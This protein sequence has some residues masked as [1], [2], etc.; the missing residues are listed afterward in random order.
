M[1]DGI[2]D[3]SNKAGNE[4]DVIK[5]A[6]LLDIVDR[7]LAERKDSSGRFWYVDTHTARPYH[8]LSSSGRWAYG[9]GRMRKRADLPP[10]F[11]NYLASSF[12]EDD[13]I[14]KKKTAFAHLGTRLYLGSSAIVYQRI[15]DKMPKLP[16]AMTLFDIDKNVALAL[17]DYYGQQQAEPVMTFLDKNQLSE[18]GKA[19]L[20][21]LWN[22][23]GQSRCL[24]IKGSSYDYLSGI[25]P[26]S[27]EQHPDLVFVD[28]HKFGDQREG[29][30][31][32]LAHCQESK[33]HFLCWTPL[34]AVP[35]ETFSPDDWSFTFHDDEKA[36]VETCQRQ[37]YRMAWFAWGSVKGAKQ[38]CYGCQ[39]TFDTSCDVSRL[40]EVVEEVR[41]SCQEIGIR[42][43]QGHFRV[44]CWPE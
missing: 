22:T 16:L 29:I 12:Y 1:D 25:C 43:K 21:A 11:A 31:R 40:R 32:V 19:A 7:L 26:L 39:L 6:F 17:F 33:T 10:I 37:N 27:A 4:G 9:V 20:N 8:R 41:S 35:E 3:H 14:T 28:P 18:H 42:T 36:F 15:K 13:L 23:L 2:Y 24:V 5:H 38:G 34:Q 30:E 44:K